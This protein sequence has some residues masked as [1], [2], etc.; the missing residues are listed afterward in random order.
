MGKTP[1]PLTILCHPDIA[2]W[3]EMQGLADQGH[4]LV[5]TESGLVELGGDKPDLILHPCAWRMDAAHRKYLALA[6]AAGRKKRYP[7]GDK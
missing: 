5:S 6:I 1:K 7:K 3:E 4:R 2:A